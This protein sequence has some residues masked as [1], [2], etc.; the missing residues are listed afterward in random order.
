MALLLTSC[1]GTGRANNSYC[2]I[3]KPIM[4][5]P[6]DALSDTTAREV[7]EHNRTGRKICGW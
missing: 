6:E 1:A 2:Q 5:G 3:A 7:L 4:I